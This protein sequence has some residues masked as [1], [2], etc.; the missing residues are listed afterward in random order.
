[1]RGI[2][3]AMRDFSNPCSILTKSPLVLRDKDLLCEIAE[4]TQ[5]S[6]CFSVPTLD[7]KTWRST[8]PHTPNPRARLEAVAELN[9]LGIP[10]GILIAPLM[11]GINDSREQVEKI[12][13]LATEAGAVHIGGITLWLRG[14]VKDVFFEWLREH[15]PDLVERYEKLYAR[16]AYLPAD[17]RRTIEQAAGAPWA[18]RTY[19]QR[20]RHRG[21]ARVGPRGGPPGARPSPSGGADR[22]EVVRSRQES[23]F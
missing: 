13:A 2:W 11:P 4:R 14:S 21:G 9:R 10:T 7:E 8:E 5:V 16:G 15:R 23:L 18:G 1:M 12:V 3:E 22:E 6:A 20:F 19:A 17:E